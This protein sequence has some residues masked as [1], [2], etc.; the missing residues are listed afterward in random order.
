MRVY[1]TAVQKCLSDFQDANLLVKPHNLNQNKLISLLEGFGWS[2]L[3]I[4][5]DNFKVD[6]EVLDKEN[7][8]YKVT[9]QG[10]VD[11]DF[12]SE[13]V[14][15]YWELGSETN[16]KYIFKPRLAIGPERLIYDSFAE[17][18][19][20]VLNELGICETELVFPEPLITFPIPKFIYPYTVEHTHTKLESIGLTC[21]QS[22]ADTFAED[23]VQE[24]KQ[25]GLLG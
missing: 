20:A 16:L 12:S 23:Y 5:E 19:C 1:S 11:I 13:L 6:S 18:E 25:V 17:D 7:Y 21:F 4:I 24:L 22:E 9:K 15:I 8:I 10:M 14:N 3:S 2:K